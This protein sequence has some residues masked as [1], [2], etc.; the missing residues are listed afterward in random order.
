MVQSQFEFHV[1]RTVRDQF[2][3]DQSIFESDGNIVFADFAAA[4]RF[5]AAINVQRQPTQQLRPGQLNAMGLIDEVLHLLMAQYREQVLPEVMAQASSVISTALGTAAYSTLLH[6]FCAQFPPIAV[7]RNEVSLDDYL[8]VEQNKHNTLEEILMLWLANANPAFAPFKELFDDSELIR[9]THYT[10]A[11]A[12]LQVFL[13][14]QP[15]FPGE[16]KNVFELLREPALKHPDSLEAQLEFLA[17]RFERISSLSLLIRKLSTRLVIGRDLIKD[18]LR[19]LAFTGGFVDFTPAKGSIPI[20]DYKADSS[21]VVHEYEAFTPDKDWMP[22]CI[23]MAKNAYVWLDQ[24][25]KKYQRAINTLDQVP[26]EELDFLRDAGVTGLWLIGLWERSIASARIKQMMGQADAVASAYSLMDYTIAGNLGGDWASNN[27]KE[28]AWQ[29]GIRMA[30]DMVPNH[31]GIDSTWVVHHPDRFLSLTY[32][33]YPSYTFNGP[34]LSN[35][36]RVGVYLEDHYYNR[37]DAAVVF[38][39]VD[40]WTGDTRYIY[41]GNDGTSM[42]WNDTAQ[43]DYL[44][45]A[46]R[47]AVIQTI[48][49]V[50][51]Q[52]PIIRF[53]AAMTLAK[54]HVKRLW[55]PQPGSGEGIA[56]RAA[57]AMDGDAFERAMPQEFWREVVDRAAIEAPDTLLLAE[58]FWMMEGYFVRTLGMHRVYNSA[59]MHMLR[60][61]DNAKYRQLIKNTIEFDSEILKRYVN[62]MNNPDEK[63]AV[64]QF[65]KGD[66]YFGVCMV[67]ATL[68]G[69][70]MLG[71]GQIEGFSEKYGM[72]FRRAKW[73]ERPDEGLIDEHR[74]RIF[75]LLHKR[76]LFADVSHFLLYDFY[77]ASNDAHNVNNINSVN[78]DVL[79]YSNGTDQER[80]L[81]IYHNRFANASGW[82]R[83]SAAYLDK[84]SNT[85]MQKTLADGL[86]LSGDPNRW[87]I[88]PDRL[89]GLEY[90]RNSRE[91]CERGLYV[92]LNA[93]QGHAFTNI[94]EVQ[95]PDGRYAQLA[96]QLDGQGVPNVSDALQELHVAPLQPALT[97]LFDGALLG[98]MADSITQ[99]ALA[100]DDSTLPIDMVSHIQQWLNA[101]QAFTQDASSTVPEPI[102][103]DTAV[104]MMASLTA[105]HRQL[106]DLLDKTESTSRSPTQLRRKRAQEYLKELENMPREVWL[107][108]SAWVLAKSTQIVLNESL[109][110]DWFDQWRANKR[111]AEQLHVAGVADWRASQ[112]AQLVGNML[113]MPGAKNLISATGL[114]SLS[115]QRWLQVNTHNGMR[116][117]NKE[118]FE[119]LVNCLFLIEIA[120]LSD[121]ANKGSKASKAGKV[122]SD[123]KAREK[124]LL[125]AYY[126]VEQALLAMTQSEFNFDK[127]LLQFTA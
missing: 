33:P 107:S 38:K 103:P 82:V 37:S 122:S 12:A 66:K 70:P 100:N 50:A 53:D 5:A 114:G 81:V 40:K 112:L 47:E 113:A 58:A 77:S 78:E 85:L 28:R 101:A 118:A 64:E 29:R 18:E 4:G 54:K 65:G 19:G 21:L 116:F 71:H 6:E 39:R 105:L 95:D 8:S 126:K 51:R 99:H 26:D 13:A 91:L 49:Q 9:I 84:G 36:E 67:M 117:F 27:L 22:R 56:S 115:A 10:P 89:N 11:I 96:T 104:H 60:D 43:L 69:L 124:G 32:P 24:L 1:A 108:L 45:P 110:I 87:V 125:N 97:Q 86:R 61:E 17:E 16:S 62:F 59:F 20:P 94:Y 75:P 7:Y 55:Y 46:V 15:K 79:V 73:D 14:T 109:P 88:L 90:L 31:F 93:Y 2:Q 120:P 111:L 127:L 72:E 30:S 25:S 123:G 80:A 102:R 92:E 74:R 98:R 68:P 3:F 57:L 52:F 121:D 119:Q 83:T 23:L 76:Y 48:L 42:P 106:D 35:D 44:N 63:T 34:D 41:H